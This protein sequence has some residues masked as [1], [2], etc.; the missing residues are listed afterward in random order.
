MERYCLQSTRDLRSNQTVCWKIKI[1]QRKRRSLSQNN[2]WLRFIR[3]LIL[4]LYNFKFLILSVLVFNM[5]TFCVHK[6]IKKDKKNQ[7]NHW[8][9]RLNKRKLSL[10]VYFLIFLRKIPSVHHKMVSHCMIIEFIILIL[11]IIN[12]FIIFPNNKQVSVL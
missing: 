7:N 5:K 2:L 6:L 11:V 1:I 4:F 3:T 10:S 8:H 9:Q 12:F